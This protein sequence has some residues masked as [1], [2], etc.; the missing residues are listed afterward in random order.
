MKTQS[1]CSLCSRM[2]GNDFD[3]TKIGSIPVVQISSTASFMTA[4]LTG[5]LVASSICKIIAPEGRHIFHDCRELAGAP[6]APSFPWP[7]MAKALLFKP[8]R[9]KAVLWKNMHM[10][11]TGDSR[12]RH[13]SLPVKSG[14]KI[15]MNLF[16]LYY[17]DTP[18]IGDE[19]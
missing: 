13:A 12:V 6:T 15:G 7:K 19:A 1:G 14:R 17:I 10:N 2:V 16:S 11:G 18:I 9:G 4:R 3:C 8:K 5:W